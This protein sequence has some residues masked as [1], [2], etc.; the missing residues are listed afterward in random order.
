MHQIDWIILFCYLICIYTIAWKSHQF[1]KKKFYQSGEPVNPMAVHYL[2]GRSLKK[3]EI[4]LSIVATEISAITFLIIPTY[5]FLQDFSYLRFVIGAVIGR[6]V[7]SKYFLNLI[8]NKGLTSF[9]VLARGINRYMSIGTMGWN[10]KRMA[11]GIYVFLKLFG[12]SARLAGGAILLSQFTGIDFIFTIFIVCTLTYFY[13]IFGGLKAV[14]RTDMLQGLVFIFGGIVAIHVIGKA[15]EYSAFDLARTAF[16]SGKF[17]FIGEAGILHFIFGMFAGFIMDISS[18]TV[19]QEMC[20]KLLGAE[21]LQ[22]AK[23]AMFYSAF[24][25]VLANLVFL[26]VGASLW[27]F[28]QTHPLPPDISSKE[29]FSH[30]ILNHF[31]SPFKGLMV[32]ALLAATMSSLDSAINAMSTCMWNDIF[33]IQLKKIKYSLFVKLDNMIMTLAVALY[34]TLIGQSKDLLSLALHLSTWASAPI[35]GIFLIRLGFPTLMKLSYSWH[36][37]L[38]AYLF[39][40]SFMGLVKLSFQA[41]DQV[42]ILVGVLVSLLFIWPYSWIMQKEKDF[43]ED[44]P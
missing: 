34:A 8:Y 21:S 24:W 30:F 23:K 14:V 2:A 5:A 20:Q 12:V 1:I 39:S 16:F 35:L 11:A 7:V 17:N 42:T 26:V 10:G 15:S 37:N 22:E 36:M 43:Y 32:A 29:V 27:A 4:F 31:P 6:L 41:S 25:S 19:D 13:L 18:H 44:L 40:I 38:F 33:P 9:E 3:H 28:Y